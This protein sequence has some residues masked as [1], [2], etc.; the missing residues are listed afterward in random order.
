[1]AVAYLFGPGPA[2]LALLLGLFAFVYFF[3]YPV[4]FFWPP[5]ATPEG[6]ARLTAFLLGTTIVAFATILMR[7]SQR[8]VERLADELA[9]AKRLAES[10]QNELETILS[11]MMG[12]V[13]VVDTD[14]KVTYANQAV[15]RLV[16]PRRD[17]GQPLEAWVRAANIREV[18]GS[19]IEMAELPLAAA[20]RGE[21]IVEKILLVDGESGPDTVISASATPIR[22]SQGGITGA[23]VIVHNITPQ[24]RL[25]GEI[26]RQKALLDTFVQSVPVGLAFIDRD[27]RYVLVNDALARVRMRP[28]EDMLGKAVRDVLPR[29]LADEAEAAIRQVFAAALPVAWR[30]YASVVGGEERYFD[31]EYLPV[32][33]S[34]EEVI[35][36]GVVIV[37]T[38]QQVRSRRELERG[39]ERERTIADTL[40]TALLSEVPRRI[41]SFEFESLY[42]AA[43]D[44]ARVG[45]DFYDVFRISPCE[46]GVVVA[47]V[48]GKGLKAAAQV[49]MAKSSIRGWAY[50]SGSPST[51][52]EQVNKTLVRAMDP[53]SF[54]TIFVGVLDCTR[55]TLTYANG[56]HVP[57]V[58]W[59]A[60][61]RRA[62]L[63][64]STGPLVGML[65]AAKYD[66]RV[67][68]LHPGDELLLATDGLYE[69]RPS[70]AHPQWVELDEVLDLYTQLK[71]SGEE[72]AAELLERVVEFFGGEFRD[73]VAILRVAVRD[74]RQT[75]SSSAEEPRSDSSARTS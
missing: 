47:D 73:D 56:G 10:R 26:E 58:L 31:V 63:L 75:S 8:R 53:E 61:E 48:S 42:R 27:L 19:E 64:D 7:R 69:I 32:R 15:F 46:I 23:V 55:G 67:I 74:A 30:D 1:M 41:D 9:E 3:V 43:T 51:V 22:D 50:E 5:A 17:L 54:V 49:A 37:E 20:L 29:P 13:I 6:W 34:Q 16:R 14:Q 12:G 18:D 4:H 62:A 66:E 65:D 36:V 25:Q 59:R 2:A 44:E 71:V 52:L 45:G 39:Y 70:E 33:T 72:S 57:A 28:I 60:G 68:E 40:Q 38:T 24:R 11:S 35:G 21:V